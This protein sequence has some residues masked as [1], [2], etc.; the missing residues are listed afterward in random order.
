MQF[1]P[2]WWEM[3]ESDMKAL[4][5]TVWPRHLAQRWMGHEMYEFGI[6]RDGRINGEAL[7]NVYK[8]LLGT[9]N[10]DNIFLFDY[11][12]VTN[13]FDNTNNLSLTNQDQSVLQYDH[14]FSS[15]DGRHL[16]TLNEEDDVCVFSIDVLG[17]SL[18]TNF[19]PIT[20]KTNRWVIDTEG[21]S[22]DD[23]IIGIPLQ[24]SWDEDRPGRIHI[25]YL[26]I[27]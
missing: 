12:M 9:Y 17:C 11:N 21:L 24:G 14:V 6:Q 15:H 16:F 2:A 4:K 26:Y 7:P 3:Y 25:K 22:N 20:G 5:R 27:N 18:I 1:F 23:K 10:M 19:K 13:K 8:D